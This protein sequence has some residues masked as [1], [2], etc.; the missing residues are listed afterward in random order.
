M[1]LQVVLISL[2]LLNPIVIYGWVSDDDGSDDDDESGSGSSKPID[3]NE[4][5]L[6]LASE[7]ATASTAFIYNRN[8]NN[9]ICS[10]V[11]IDKFAIITGKCC[12]H[13]N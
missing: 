2:I 13:L 12:F 10:G 6:K 5:K 11:L 1:R 9:I 7:N 4:V 3:F 8:S